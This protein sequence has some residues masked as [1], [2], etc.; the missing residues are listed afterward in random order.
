MVDVRWQMKTALDG[1][2]FGREDCTTKAQMVGRW[3]VIGD[4]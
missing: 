3:A 4:R 2:C 1:G